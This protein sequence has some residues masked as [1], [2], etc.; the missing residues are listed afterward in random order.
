MVP[1]LPALAVGGL[2]VMGIISEGDGK[3]KI[4]YWA[5]LIISGALAALPFY[6]LLFV[7]KRAKPKEEVGAAAP[8]AASA[9]AESTELATADSAEV[10]AAGEEEAGEDIFAA[11]EDVEEAQD[12]DDAETFEDEEK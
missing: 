3:L 5:T 4:L 1:W 10:E 7:G 2:S 9:P 8:A 11:T 12:L 6:V